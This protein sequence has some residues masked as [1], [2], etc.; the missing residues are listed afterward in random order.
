MPQKRSEAVDNICGEVPLKP[1]TSVRFVQNQD[2][3]VLLDI[4]QN[5]CLGMTPT[6]VR[7]WELLSL[8]RSANDITHYLAAECGVP[9]VQ[10]VD[11]V[12]AFIAELMNNGL[13]FREIPIQKMTFRDWVMR[14]MVNSRPVLHRLRA[15]SGGK[16]RFLFWRS[17]I[18]LL[19]F[20][21]LRF[22]RDFSKM[23][24]FVRNW[25]LAPFSAPSDAI[26][27]VCKAVNFACVWYPRRVLCLQRS[28]VL[29]CLL[30]SSGVAAQMV[31]G[32][33]KFPFKA[34]AWTEVNNHA[35][36]ERRDVQSIY[37]VWE[38]C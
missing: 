31:I 37:L 9:E 13:L 21:L 5:L 24:D 25:T 23:H 35:I 1:S 36:N 14:L 33:Q 18:A 32:A 10:I 17:L 7:I 15:R 19:T 27:Q 2:G 22:S 26:D 20:D 30:R 8:N 38:R 3:A 12:K 6:A 34:H 4:Q 16:L 29:T 28:A 11:D